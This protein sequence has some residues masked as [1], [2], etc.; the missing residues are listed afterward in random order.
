M[1]VNEIN[2]QGSRQKERGKGATENFN[3]S[4]TNEIAVNPSFFGSSS[5]AR[6]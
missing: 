3:A 5:L 2:A 4:V 6:T 1:R